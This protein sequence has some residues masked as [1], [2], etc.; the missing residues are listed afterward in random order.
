MGSFGLPDQAAEEKTFSLRVRS[1]SGEILDAEAS[2]E[3]YERPRGDAHLLGVPDEKDGVGRRHGDS[4]QEVR[5]MRLH[6]RHHGLEIE[7][8]YRIG[9]VVGD[10]DVLRF[11]ERQSRSRDRFSEHRVVVYYSSRFRH[12]PRHLADE[13]VEGAGING[14]SGAVAEDPL[15]PLCSDDICGRVVHHVG[16]LEP[17]GD[18]GDLDRLPR[19]A[20]A[21]QAEDLVLVDQFFGDRRG[22]RVLR[23]MVFDDYFELLPVYAARRVDLL[24]RHVVCLLEFRAERCVGPGH[25]LGSADPESIVRG[26]GRRK[27]DGYK[28]CQNH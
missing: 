2:A 23:L 9:L 6:L 4:E 11:E 5:V 7:G 27:T 3:P 19:G 20:P 17:L 25:R 22:E 15:E 12:R 24:D 16:G 8:V 21:R 14:P 26:S 1:S 18:R 10:G 28:T 13:A